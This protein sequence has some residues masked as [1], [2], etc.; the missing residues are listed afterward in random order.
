MLS[1][2]HFLSERLGFGKF[3]IKTFLIVSFIDFL[4]GAEIQYLSF[5]N[6]ILM[7]EWELDL[8][9]LILLAASFNLGLF[10][11]AIICALQ[12]D[13]IG[14][15]NILIFGSFLQVNIIIILVLHSFVNSIR[16]KFILNVTVKSF[17]WSNIW[18]NDSH[19]LN[20]DDRMH[21]L[22]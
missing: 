20:F 14:R 10:I 18:N 17:V 7:K 22:R 21:P 11:G 19:F 12:A 4:D 16:V 1:F 15:R 5:L 9:G 13:K 2:D 8:T 6:V 3:Q